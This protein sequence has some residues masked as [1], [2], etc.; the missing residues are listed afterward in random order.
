[1][2]VELK[3]KRRLTDQ[4]TRL[5]LDQTGHALNEEIDDSDRWEARYIQYVGLSEDYCH[6]H[7]IPFDKEVEDAKETLAALKK[8]NLPVTD[9][10]LPDG[11]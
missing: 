9:I 3:L 1:M 7:N 10:F 2:H 5:I 6:R 8:M 4:E 11:W